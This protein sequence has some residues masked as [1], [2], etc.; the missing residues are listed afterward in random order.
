MSTVAVVTSTPPLAEGGHLVI[1]RALVE[2]LRAAGHEA[3]LVLTPQNRFGRNLSTYVASWLTDVERTADGRHVDQVISLRWPSYAV[4]HSRHVSWLNHT[5]REYYDLWDRFSATLSRPARVKESV[6]RV[7]IR[8]ADTWLLAHHVTKLVAQSAT[9]RDRL[10]R[11]NGLDA[12]VLHPPA[13]PRQYRC[14]S[15]EPFFFTV[16]RFTPLKRLDLLVEA[17]ALPEAAGIRAVLAGDGETWNSVRALVEARGLSDRVTLPGRI[18]D[19]TLLDYYARCRAVVFLPADEDYGFV[20]VEAFASGKAVITATDSG[21]PAELVQDGV[22]GC[23]SAPSAEAVA[24][25]LRRLTDDPAA[26]ERLGQA[27]AATAASM[28]WPAAVDR[29]LLTSH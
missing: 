18:D 15:Y 16:S 20:T 1:A 11:F 10:R 27:A 28:S 14:E 9:I 6:R 12:E 13:P 19:R 5:A 22:T 24:R 4:R 2:A 25:A 3:D 17:L 7:L 21:G 8:R 26:A 29:L 23:V